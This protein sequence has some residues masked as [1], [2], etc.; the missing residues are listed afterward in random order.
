MKKILSIILVISILS[1]LLAVSSFAE[2]AY[3]ESEHNYANNTDKVWTYQGADDTEDIRITF[4]EDF[5]LGPYVYYDNQI[6]IEDK[7]LTQEVVDA[8]EKD[9][10]YEKAMC[11]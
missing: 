6:V 1:G 5:D 7:N 3:P 11:C 4:S 10:Y 2:S 9:G 8:I